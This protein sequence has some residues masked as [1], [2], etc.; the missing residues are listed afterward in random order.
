LRLLLQSK[1]DV[2]QRD[3]DDR[4]PLHVASVRGHADCLTALLQEGAWEHETAKEEVRRWAWHWHLGPTFEA[5]GVGIGA[6]PPPRCSSRTSQQ[7]LQH[8]PSPSPEDPSGLC[9]LPSILTTATPQEAVQPVQA[10]SPNPARLT[11]DRMELLRVQESL[12]SRLKT[13]IRSNSI[14]DIELLVQQ[15]ACML[16]HY[17]SERLQ[18][19][20]KDGAEPEGCWSSKG[21]TAA[22][23]NPVDW[24]ALEGHFDAALQLLELGD[25]KVVFG[26]DEH[27]THFTRLEL[28]RDTRQAVYCAAFRGQRRLLAALLERNADPAQKNAQDESALF[29]AVRENRREAAE[30]LLSFGAWNAEERKHEVLERATARRMA[31]VLD[32]A[33]VTAK[34]GDSIAG[35]ASEPLPSWEEMVR[36]LCESPFES[37]KPYCVKRILERSHAQERSCRRWQHRSESPANRSSAASARSIAEEDPDAPPQTLGETRSACLQLNT[38]LTLAIKKGDDKCISGLVRHGAALDGAFDLGYGEHGNCI[39]W[40]CVS[41]QPGVALLLLELA[42]SSRLEFAQELAVHARAALFWSVV[43]GY[44][45]VLKALLRLGADPG[46]RCQSGSGD[47]ALTLAVSSW[48]EDEAMELLKHGAWDSEPEL[49][50]RDLIRQAQIRKPV[51]EALERAGI[52]FDSG[53]FTGQGVCPPVASSQATGILPQVTAVR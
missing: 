14:V 31:C 3:C 25:G 29:V 34:P 10:V 9:Q 45:E 27:Q 35:L 51:A 52:S 28:A 38:E 30:V 47:S 36:H 4:S 24:A 43:E 21:P 1:C 16:P 48:R 22:L 19:L 32:V 13:A 8:T 53:T 20:V 46:Q 41:K 6:S 5:A 11:D 26:R 42:Q 7:I 17:Y 40:A 44:L 50:R 12:R 23:V 37:D 2:A 33:G 49:S 15:G 39:D 18:V